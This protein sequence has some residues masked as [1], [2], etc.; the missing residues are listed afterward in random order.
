M[1]QDILQAREIL[2]ML[3]RREFRARYAGSN[4]GALWNLIHPI[5]LVVIYVAI[6]SKVMGGKMGVNGD[7][8]RLDYLIH[9]TSGMIPWLLFSEIVNRSCSVLVENSNLLKK[10]ALP[11][12]VLFI[13]VFSTSFLVYSISMIALIGFLIMLGQPPSW[14][15][16]LVFP[17]MIALGLS[18]LGLGMVLAVLNLL[19]RDV[20]QI[21]AITLQLA[22][23]SLPIVYPPSILSAKLQM[24]VALNPIRGFFSLIQLIFGSPQANFNPDTYW[25]MV[26][27]PFAAMVMGMAFLRAQRSE[28][29]D[30]L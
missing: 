8:N 27:L 16:L 12:E 3:I 9:L 23:W 1:L 18:A 30:A 22:F 17:I 19:I 4:F 13:S 20:G 28:I 21:V 11:E 10:M 15:V 29:L 26:L 6:F 7:G 2:F 25:M 5:V 14:Q 24:I